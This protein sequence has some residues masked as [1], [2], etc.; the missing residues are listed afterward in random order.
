MHKIGLE[1][2]NRCVSSCL[3]LIWDLDLAACCPLTLIH[4]SQGRAR[5][6]RLRTLLATIR[7]P[8]AYHSRQPFLSTVFPDLISGSCLAP[9]FHFTPLQGRCSSNIH[10]GAATCSGGFVK[11]FLSVPLAC[12]G[13]MAAAVQAAQRPGNSQKTCFKTFGTSCRPR[14][15]I[16]CIPVV[17]STVL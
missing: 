5:E 12:S 14:L 11:C 17:S 10:S 6:R 2:E 4:S 15:Y 1:F 9:T 16:Q 3:P 13:S 8:T 7:R